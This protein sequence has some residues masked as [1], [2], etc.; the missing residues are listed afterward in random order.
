MILRISENASEAEIKKS[1]RKLAMEL[2][3]DRNPDAPDCEDKFKDVTEAYGVLIDPVKR[4]EYDRHWAGLFTETKNDDYEFRYSQRDIYENMFRQGYGRDIFN[5]LNREFNR[6]GFR[7]GKSF[8]EAI[9]FGGAA[10]GLGRILAFMPGPIGKLGLGLRI[11]QAVGTSLYTLSKM[12]KGMSKTPSV[13]GKSKSAPSLKKSLRRFFGKSGGPASE[14]LDINFNITILEADAIAGAKKRLTYSIG[15][16]Q[17]H[18]LVS[19]PPG[20]ISGGKLRIKAKGRIK[21]NH[22]GDLILTINHKHA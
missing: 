19:I 9:L 16:K 6:Q 21:N 11:I 8:F 13:D 18:L 2:H 22:R 17:E 20:T 7:S 14:N 15:V 4:K 1:F 5:E 10:G 12:R 3:P